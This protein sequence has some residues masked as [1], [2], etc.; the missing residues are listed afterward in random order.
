MAERQPLPQDPRRFER[1]LSESYGRLV[2][3]LRRRLPERISA[4]DVV[5]EALVRAWQMSEGG[6]CIRSLEGWMNTA[7]TNLARSHWRTLQAEDR[8]LERI[9]TD[10][11][12]VGWATLGHFS[13]VCFAGP[14]RDAVRNLP[15]RQ[16]EVVVLHYY[17]DMAL[18]DIAALLGLSEGAV[19]SA[20][21]DARG[22][23]RRSLGGD[24]QRRTK[25]RSNMKPWH[26]AGS[27][28]AEYD[29]EPAGPVS[30]DGR[31]AVRLS[32]NARQPSGFGTLM[33]TF[34]ADDYRDT[35]VRFSGALKCRGVEDRVGLWMRVDG[36]R[37]TQPLAF[38]NMESRPVRAT[39]EWARHDV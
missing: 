3:T 36:P 32:C 2:I 6:V 14:V 26:M 31:P 27:H 33:Q 37:G 9:A 5:Q 30:P 28:P 21:H 34:A 35:R 4:E 39:S 10:R 19:K 24:G 38:D 1:Y 25:Q 29:H 22:Q 17:G 12:H 18:R 8:T 11:S 13:P 20:L 23:L 15:R 16:R 7:A